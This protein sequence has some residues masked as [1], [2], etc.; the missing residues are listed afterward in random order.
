MLNSKVKEKAIKSSLE[1]DIRE[2]FYTEMRIVSVIDFSDN[3][4]EALSGKKC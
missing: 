4:N 3:I 2:I 1:K